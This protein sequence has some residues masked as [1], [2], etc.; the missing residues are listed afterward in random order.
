[1]SEIP[2]FGLRAFLLFAALPFGLQ[3]LMRP[4]DFALWIILWAGYMALFAAV[5]VWRGR[6]ALGLMAP[7]A[8][9]AGAGF[10]DAPVVGPTLFAAWI[11]VLLLTASLRVIKRISRA[12]QQVTAC[13]RDSAQ[14][15]SVAAKPR[16]MDVSAADILAHFG[17]ENGDQQ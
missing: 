11:F 4:E 9:F 5:N 7:T 16:P 6:V 14:L 3:L 17:L 15:V 1:M 12:R 13:N 8:A 10:M 2:P